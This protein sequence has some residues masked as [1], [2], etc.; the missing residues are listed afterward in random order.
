MKISFLFSFLLMLA[1]NMLMAQDQNRWQMA[2]KY[3]MDIDLDTKKHQFKGVQKLILY[4]NSPDELKKVFYHLYFNAFQPGSM[5][6]ERSRS[7][8][9]PDPRVG[10]RISKLKP[11]ETGWTK[12]KT[13]KHNG[14]DVKFHIEETILEVTLNE[15]IKP[16]A[17]DTFYMEFESQIPIQIRRNGR[18][19]D[20]GIDY[21]MSQW[22]PKMCNYDYQGWH[23]NPYVGREFYGIWGDFDVKIT[24][25]KNYIIGA[26][27]YLQNKNEIGHGYEDK[28]V[29]IDNSKKNKLTWHFY[30][31]MVHD[32][33]WGADPDY[34][35]DIVMLDDTT[36]IHFF[37]QDDKDFNETWKKSQQEMVKAFQF[38]EKQYGDYPY[39]QY[40]FV[41]GGDGGMEYPMGTLITGKRSFPSL[42]GVMIHELMHT[43]YQMLMGTNEALYAWMDEGFTSYSSA[44]VQNHLFNKNAA[45]MPVEQNMHKN[46]YLGYFATSRA[47]IE[48]PLTVHADHYMTNTA[49]GSGA[50][51][52]GAVFLHQLE[53]IIGKEAFDKGMLDYYQAWSFKHPNPNDFIRI[54]EKRSGLELDWYREYWVNTVH[55]V[56]YAVKSVTEDKKETKIVLERKEWNDSKNI[57]KN[58][59]MP[60][61]IDL[62]IE[63]ED[64]KEIKKEYYY[65]PLDLMRGEKA[66]EG[67]F[68]KRTILKDWSWTHKNYEFK[69]PIRF[70]NIVKISI[71]PTTRLADVDEKNN[72]WQAVQK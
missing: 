44:V 61:P 28:G 17:A 62:L 45:S 54:M 18:N 34:L 48:E 15:P 25:P 49:Y 32:F 23:A 1:V 16:G 35:H 29:I 40:S 58:G 13:L 72:S 5:M 26:T 55:T 65:I 69:L 42:V 2:C 22:Y 14:K 68:G 19:S 46:S 50:Y 53:Y 6:D 33:F 7:L 31:P 39:R 11:E 24:L 64:G 37:Y 56:D 52:K 12:V 51:N 43:W 36:E 21:S 70:K 4:N 3:S 60:M 41:Q 59:R 57:V 47:G 10:S 38:I 67:F 63:Y 20:E 30:A 66:D 71:D 9:D 8:P 27:G